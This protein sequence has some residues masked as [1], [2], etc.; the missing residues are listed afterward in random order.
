MLL[1]RCETAAVWGWYPLF[2]GAQ[3]EVPRVLAGLHHPVLSLVTTKFMKICPPCPLFSARPGC[4]SRY[5][6]RSILQILLE[7]YLLTGTILGNWRHADN[8]L[9]N[10]VLG[11]LALHKL[12]RLQSSGSY[13]N[14]AH[15]ERWRKARESETLRT[16]FLNLWVATPGGLTPIP[17]V[18]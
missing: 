1:S 16:A 15:G 3:T 8:C 2:H 6:R 14:K 18:T 10:I 9:I 4:S 5:N 17:G 13:L 11:M 12:W 7:V